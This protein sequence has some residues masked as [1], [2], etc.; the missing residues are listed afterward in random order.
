MSAEICRKAQI[1][2]LMDLQNLY[3]YER[4]AVKGRM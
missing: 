2:L 1:G 4:S 3:V